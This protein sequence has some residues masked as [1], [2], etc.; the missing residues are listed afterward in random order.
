[1]DDL[2]EPI[3]HIACNKA[4][5]ADLDWHAQLREAANEAA[6]LAAADLSSENLI[7][8]AAD[9][10]SLVHCFDARVHLS[11]LADHL[12]C[13]LQATVVLIADRHSHGPLQAVLLHPFVAAAANKMVLMQLMR[14]LSPTAATWLFRYLQRWLI[15]ISGALT[16]CLFTMRMAAS[17]PP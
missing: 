14:G 9:A 1:M 7:Q 13:E 8:D 3:R 17:N 15:N 6:D 10:A 11:C 16:M 4:S 5:P 2:R 12:H